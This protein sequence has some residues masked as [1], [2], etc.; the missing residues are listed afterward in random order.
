MGDISNSQ[1]LGAVIEVIP[2]PGAAPLMRVIGSDSGF[3]GSTESIAHFGL[4]P[5]QNSVHQVTIQWPSGLVQE[6]FDVS[7]NTVLS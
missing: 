3:L 4:G 7:T 5:D 2:E 6:F 1:G